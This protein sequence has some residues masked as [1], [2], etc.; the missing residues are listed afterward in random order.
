MA[1]NNEIFTRILLWSETTLDW[2][3]IDDVILKGEVALEF[4]EGS[5]VPKIKVGDGTK[6]FSELGY[7]TMTPAEI[8]ALINEITVS[9]GAHSHTNKEALDLITEAKITSWDNVATEAVRGVQVDGVD[10]EKSGVGIVN[11]TKAG[12]GID[13]VDNTADAEKDVKSAGKL[14]TARN[15]TVKGDASGS[16]AFDGSADVEMQVTVDR[17]GADK[18]DG[19]IPVENLPAGALE[20]CVVVETDEARFALTTAD[21]QKGDTVKVTSTGLMYMIVDDAKLAEEAGYVEYTAGAATTVPWAGITGKPTEFTPEAHT[22]SIN[23]ITDYTP[24]TVDTALDENS[25]NAVQN[26]AIA[27][28]FAEIDA[29]IA[30]ILYVA[31]AISSFSNNVNTKELGQTVNDVTLTWKTNKTPT[32][33]EVAGQTLDVK[34]TSLALTNQN[35][36]GSAP[37]VSKTYTIKVTDNRGAS[38]TKNTT[39]SFQN[40]RFWWVA[41][42]VVVDSATL[43]AVPSNGQELTNSRAKTF[44]L[45][46]GDGQYIYYAFPARL[47]SSN[48]INFNVGGFDGGFSLVNTFDFTNA[49]GYTESYKV[50]RSDNAGLGSTTVKVS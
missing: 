43:L 42:D 22:H 23:D 38:A 2:A 19:V 18:I 36:V 17:V 13:K 44:T 30:D 41:G 31:I 49:S 33:L 48:A 29:Q 3:S 7:A 37:N 26:K 24:P 27:T 25:E 1:V 46:A 9:Q 35:I 21:V 8:Q 32:T 40:R 16:V 5:N 10:V 12:L 47:D 28:K 14:T 34:Q 11:I 45:N 39:I 20:R 15:I 4:T 50:Y 6:K